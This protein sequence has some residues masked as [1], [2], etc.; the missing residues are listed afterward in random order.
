[1]SFHLILRD[2]SNVW[3]P[4]LQKYTSLY[5]L[6]SCLLKLYLVNKFYLGISNNLT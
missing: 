1:M 5:N 2:F 6:L 3:M 4:Y